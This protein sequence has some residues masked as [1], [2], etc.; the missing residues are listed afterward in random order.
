MMVENEKKVYELRLSDFNPLKPFA[1]RRRANDL[2]KQYGAC[3]QYRDAN[4]FMLKAFPRNII[5]E[6]CHAAIL[7][8]SAGALIMGLTYAAEQLSYKGFIQ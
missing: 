1:Y 8:I 6:G 3:E 4:I 7:G 5:V 2:I